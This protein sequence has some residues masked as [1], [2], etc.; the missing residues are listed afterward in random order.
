MKEKDKPRNPLNLSSP[1]TTFRLRRHAGL[2]AR[3]WEKDTFC[4]LLFF[5]FVDP[6]P[7]SFLRRKDPFVTSPG[8]WDQGGVSWAAEGREADR[9]LRPPLAVTLGARGTWG[10]DVNG[11][12]LGLGVDVSGG[13]S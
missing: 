12:G 2:K 5:A 10:P 11:P 1:A 7:H 6:A 8:A 9:G 4:T 13:P 3:S